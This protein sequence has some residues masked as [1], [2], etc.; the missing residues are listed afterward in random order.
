[1]PSSL[2]AIDSN[3]PTFTGEESPKQQIQAMHNYLFQ[4]REGLQYSLRNLSA[5]NFNAA[6]LENLSESQKSEV[7]NQ[8]TQVY[9]LLNQLGAKVDSL[10][11]RITGVENLGS[12]VT[13]TEEEISY[14]DGRVAG[15]EQDIEDLTQETSEH[16][17]HLAELDER[18]SAVEAALPALEEVAADL[19]ALEE[20]ISGE[21]GITEQLE[22][23]QADTRTIQ[24]Q[25]NA[26]AKSQAKTAEAVQVAEDGGITIGAEN[27]RVDLTGEIY[28][29]GVLFTQG[30]AT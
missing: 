8:L 2:Q 18:V 13:D 25:L 28:I 27:K 15:A 21:G 24:E 6:A 19:L 9:S 29:N 12:R 11:G 7:A 23:L 14:L 20:L 30:E 4:L 16:E 3:F 17:E 22:G 26:V 5:E 1:M 10:S